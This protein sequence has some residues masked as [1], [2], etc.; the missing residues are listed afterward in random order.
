[1]SNQYKVSAWGYQSPNYL[2]V[3]PWGFSTNL[4]EVVLK[5]LKLGPNNP[6]SIYYG[7]IPISKVYYGSILIYTA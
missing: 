7:S 6:A 5:N 1:M 4:G 3:S 2:E